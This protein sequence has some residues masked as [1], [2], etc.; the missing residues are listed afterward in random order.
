MYQIVSY[1]I[2]TLSN[3]VNF[4]KQFCT[5]CISFILLVAFQANA[6]LLELYENRLCHQ[7]KCYSIASIKNTRYEKLHC[8]SL[9]AEK[10]ERNGVRARPPQSNND[11]RP[12][13]TE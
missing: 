2:E 5:L 12:L 1:Q 13:M 11:L 3:F 7:C 6:T 10:G 9:H 8:L 4:E